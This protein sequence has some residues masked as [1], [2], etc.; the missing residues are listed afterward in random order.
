MKRLFVIVGL[1]W[2]F[3]L[4]AAEVIPPVPEH[5]FNDYAHV[6]SPGTASH[7]NQTLEDFERQT[8]NQILVAI[9]PKMQSDS[10]IEELH[11]PGGACLESR[12]KSQK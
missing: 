10:S 4:F 6:V 5:Y 7:L 11:S 2:C 9:Y 8:S 3:S 1:L 12:S